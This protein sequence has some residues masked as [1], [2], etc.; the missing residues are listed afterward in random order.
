MIAR[1]V[2]KDETRGAMCNM[3]AQ[4]K[5]AAEAIERALID[6]MHE[7][8]Y[9]TITVKQIC[10]R[11]HVSR[12][13]YYRSFSSKEDVLRHHLAARMRRMLPAG[14]GELPDEH[15]QEHLERALEAIQHDAELFALVRQ[16][17]L[18]HVLYEF[19][20]SEGSSY[21]R[22]FQPGAVP[23]QD[24]YYAGGTLLVILDWIGHDMPETPHELAA[25][26]DTLYYRRNFA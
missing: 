17:G 16:A 25:I 6:L 20:L 21:I 24:T 23:Y 4:G 19:F 2:G 11:A 15:V 26:I 18:M 13:S 9:T 14:T 7:Q 22:R 12:V 5:T 3:A 1:M 8:P 10:A